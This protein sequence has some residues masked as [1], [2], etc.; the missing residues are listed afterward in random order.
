MWSSC[1]DGGACVV[2]LLPYMYDAVGHGVRYE[3]DGNRSGREARA[4]LGALSLT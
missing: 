4:A 1:C 2:G 3:S